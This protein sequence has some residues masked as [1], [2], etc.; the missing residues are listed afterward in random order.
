LLQDCGATS[1]EEALVFARVIS[2]RT[3]ADRIDDAVRIAKEQLPGA[4]GQHGYHGMYV[5]ADR[6]SGKIMT[7]SLWNSREDLK[8]VEARA[9]QL[10][11]EAAESISVATSPVDIYEVEIADRA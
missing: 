4:Q 3:A 2:A 11:D 5:L 9:V 7:I 8:A 6:V 1:Q 10:R